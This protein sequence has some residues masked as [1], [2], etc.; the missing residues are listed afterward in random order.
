[1]FS[2]ATLAVLFVLSVSADPA[3]EREHTKTE[4][5]KSGCIELGAVQFVA[6]KSALKEKSPPVLVSLAEAMKEDETLRLKIIVHAEADKNMELAKTRAGA[7]RT[8]LM[9]ETKAPISRLPVQ[10]IEKEAKPPEGCHTA[11]A[12]AINLD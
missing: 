2:K 9:R 3:A 7:I 4:L 12:Y 1:M 6:G 11:A 8:W 5:Y 10:A